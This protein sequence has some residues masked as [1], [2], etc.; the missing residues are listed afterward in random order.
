VSFLDTDVCYVVICDSVDQVRSLAS[1]MHNKNKQFQYFVLDFDS[2]NTALHGSHVVFQ[3]AFM[4]DA[5][6][7]IMRLYNQSASVGLNLGAGRKPFEIVVVGHSVGGMVAR[8]AVLLD[9][10]P[11]CVIKNMVLLSTP[12]QRPPYSFDTS[13]DWL[14]SAVNKAWKNSYFNESKEC[15]LSQYALSQKILKSRQLDDNLNEIPAD[16]SVAPAE[17]TDINADWNCPVCARNIRVLSISG[18][19]VDREVSSAFTHLDPIAPR[20][21]NVSSTRAAA[22]AKAA[23]LY[24][25]GYMWQFM[26][27]FVGVPPRIIKFPYHVIMGTVGFLFPGT[28]LSANST[29]SSSVS[30]PTNTTAASVPEPVDASSACVADTCVAESNNDTTATVATAEPNNSGTPASYIMNYSAYELHFKGITEEAWKSDMLSYTEPQHFSVRTMQ[31]ADIKFPVDHLAILWCHQVM[32]SVT[33]AMRVMVSQTDKPFV[34]YNL[35]VDVDKPVPSAGF[36][37]QSQAVKDLYNLTAFNA[38][39]RYKYM[40]KCDKKKYIRSTRLFSEVI[41]PLAYYMQRNESLQTWRDAED[42][43]YAHV[44]SKL[45]VSSLGKAFAPMAG[46]LNT[47]AFKF[48]TFELMH[49]VL[50]YMVTS[51]LIAASSILRSL[52]GMPTVGVSCWTQCQPSYHLAL[53]ILLPAAKKGIQYAGS[54]TPIPARVLSLLSSLLTTWLP[55]GLYVGYIGYYLLVQPE[56][57]VAKC[58]TLLFVPA[59]YGLA[60]TKRVVILVAV[61]VIRYVFH[62]VVGLTSWLLRW[63]IWCKPIRRAVRSAVGVVVAKV[64]GLVRYKNV[65]TYKSTVAFVNSRWPT[66]ISVLVL[67]LVVYISGNRMFGTSNSRIHLGFGNFL[68]STL[69]VQLYLLIVLS[70]A[71]LVLYP[72]IHSVSHDKTSPK[73]SAA[74]DERGTELVLLYWLVVPAA[75]PNAIYS[76]KLLFDDAKSIQMLLPVLSA[77]SPDRITLVMA[78]SAI[79]YHISQAR[80]VRYWLIYRSMVLYCFHWLF[81]LQLLGLRYQAGTMASGD[82]E[83]VWR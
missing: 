37:H 14:Y 38:T 39:A 23:A 80:F 17:V 30:V 52:I 60:L 75:W 24:E 65:P 70:L 41:S 44:Q 58:D 12:N 54:F 69:S 10:H 29:E 22:A 72:S 7:E 35:V 32:S 68:W 1:L 53:D 83:P 46:A 50:A 61:Q 59:V 63:T 8:T 57:F 9:N 45:S 82:A 6:R 40:K 43:E 71:V 5:L 48:A 28:A 36:I 67:M 20:P 79:Y 77:F 19:I 2:A 76:L 3:A 4:N 64:C 16:P 55:I 25:E 49:V 31:M 21:V 27:W 74:A 34:D 33:R 42:T 62:L 73:L 13:N 81:L 51:C 18:G 78:L 26:R 11:A 56:K 47:L 66:Y 15:R